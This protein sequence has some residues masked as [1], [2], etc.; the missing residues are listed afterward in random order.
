MCMFGIAIIFDLVAG[1][2][3]V[4]TFFGAMAMV[5]VMMMLIK[6]AKM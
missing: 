4:G 5:H 3:C 2:A 6:E 1:G